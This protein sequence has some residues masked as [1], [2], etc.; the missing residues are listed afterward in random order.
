M[1]TIIKNIRM[2]DGTPVPSVQAAVEKFK[3]P[4]PCNPDCPLYP[5]IRIQGERFGH[6]CH[7]EI[8]SRYPVSV[9][10]A[11]RCSYE[12]VIGDTAPTRY[13]AVIKPHA[14]RDVQFCRTADTDPL[15]H[16]WEDLDDAL[17]WLGFFE[18]PDALKKAADYGR[19]VPE[20]IMLI[21]VD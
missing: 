16:D 13:A 2:T 10:D 4:G 14:V 9:L 15:S 21:P 1:S 11:M 17:V 5:G 19:T 6:M 3:C 20:N 18:G 7:P 12:T 8:V